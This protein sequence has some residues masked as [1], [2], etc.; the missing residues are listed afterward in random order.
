MT[1]TAG[2]TADLSGELSKANGV[3]EPS[4][5]AHWYALYTRSR[6]EQL[7]Y[8]QLA[9]K[10]FHVFLPKLE[11]W[12]RRAGQ[13]HLIAIPMFPSYL[14]LHHT[15]DKLGYLEVRKPR[16]LVRI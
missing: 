4:F 13:Q 3:S 7:V 12:S 2:R 1:V 9:T 11:V 6:C 15:M 8:T 16:G 5:F 10:G 14:F